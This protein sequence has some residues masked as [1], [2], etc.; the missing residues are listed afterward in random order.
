MF[1]YKTPTSDWI[2][3]M[4]HEAVTTHH[5][6]TKMCRHLN[7]VH[8]YNISFTLFANTKL[9]LLWILHDWLILDL[10]LS[11]IQYIGLMYQ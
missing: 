2:N 8:T 3:V 4:E 7:G 1:F 6:L 10:F 5:F 9:Y 11:P